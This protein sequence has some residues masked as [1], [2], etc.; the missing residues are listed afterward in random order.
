MIESKT[1]KMENDFKKTLKEK[2][3]AIREQKAENSRSRKKKIPSESF[4]KRQGNQILLESKGKFLQEGLYEPGDNQ[5][6]CG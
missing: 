6:Y 5:G 3:D 2:I 1:E 4:L